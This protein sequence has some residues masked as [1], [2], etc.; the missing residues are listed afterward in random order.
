MRLQSA[1]FY[2]E[3]TLLVDGE[4]AKNA[5]KVL[6]ILKMEGVWM[7]A[8]SAM[9]REK[10]EKELRLRGLLSPLRL[11]L[12]SKEACVAIDSGELLLKAV[13]RLRAELRDTVVFCSNVWQIETAARAG[14]RTVAVKNAANAS[15]W[16][17]LKICATEAIEG[18]EDLLED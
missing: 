11:L 18:Y 3:D 17:T 7:A 5:E 8:V 1:I 15:E 14:F 4:E 12:V 9:E 13:R 16:E 2:L 10:A 6:S